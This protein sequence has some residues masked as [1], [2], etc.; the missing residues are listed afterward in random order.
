[1]LRTALRGLEGAFGFGGC[2]K[3]PLTVTLSLGDSV[4]GI[5]ISLAYPAR[6]NL[7]GS[8]STPAVRDRVVL[9]FDGGLSAVGDL[10][11]NNDG[12]DDTL[13]VSYV[14]LNDNPAGLFATVTFDACFQ[15]TDPRPT[16]DDFACVVNSASTSEGIPVTT[17]C[18]V[19]VLP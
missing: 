17:S 12:S 19:G 11:T 2:V 3:Q 1:M 7:P 16:A 4:A 9:A 6:V 10:D 15:D 18:T 8:Q 13:R 5:A 14:S